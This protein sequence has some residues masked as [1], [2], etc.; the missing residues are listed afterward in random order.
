MTSSYEHIT[1]EP[2]EQ[3]QAAYEVPA[4]TVIGAVSEFT[5][6]LSGNGQDMGH[7]GKKK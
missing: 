2:V 4:I 3:D 6:G 5:L 1:D 7:R